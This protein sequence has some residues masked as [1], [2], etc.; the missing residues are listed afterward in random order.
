MEWIQQNLRGLKHGKCEEKSVICDPDL[1]AIWIQLR[2]NYGNGGWWCPERIWT[3]PMTPDVMNVGDVLVRY[4]PV[5]ILKVKDL[6]PTYE[7]Q[8][9][10]PTTTVSG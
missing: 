1:K 6:V 4:E 2:P 9:R 7:T 3:V 8:F 10:I 5:E